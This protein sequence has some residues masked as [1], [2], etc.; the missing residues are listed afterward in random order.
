[1]CHRPL[2]YK[3][4][5]SCVVILGIESSCDETAAAILKDGKILANVVAGQAVH[6]SY[7]GVVPELASRAHQSNIVPVVHETLKKA[8][9]PGADI[10]AVAYTQGPGL[11]GS[12]L[13]GSSFAKS[14]ALALA[15][16]V[17]PVNHMQ[18]HVLSLLLEN[19]LTFPFLCLTVSGG[20]TQIVRADAPL[21]MKV[22]GETADDAAGEAFDKAA[23]VLGLPYPGGPLIDQYAAQG[24]SKRFHFPKPQMPGMSFSFSGLK[25]SFVNLVQKMSPEEKN[26]SLND[27]CASYQAVIV[28]ILLSKLAIAVNTTGITRVAIAGGVA[29]N[30]GLRSAL[31]EAEKRQGWEVFIPSMRYCT[32]NAS[33]IALSGYYLYKSGITG[34]QK[35]TSHARLPL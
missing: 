14:F 18:G 5:H 11:L 26:A 19:T 27:I 34:D 23:K 30:S 28:D 12:L 24:D 33:M 8:G 10:D 32:D 6:S 4:N 20:H 2:P 7:G 1:M 35:D 22:L 16:P 15:I 17:I 29:A 3:F 31:K 9:I 21:K 25:T 13:V